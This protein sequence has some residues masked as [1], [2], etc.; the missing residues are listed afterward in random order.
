MLRSRLFWCGFL[1]I[2]VPILYS[3]VTYFIAGLP[4]L[5][6]Y[7]IAYDL[8]IGGSVPDLWV[9]ILPML[10]IM[11]YLCPLDILGSFILFYSSPL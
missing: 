1:L 3:I 4:P 10:M 6:F 8:K 11:L 7:W 2:F 5:D 9:R